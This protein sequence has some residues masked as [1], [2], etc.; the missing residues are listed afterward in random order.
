MARKC[1]KE[2]AIGQLNYILGS[3]HLLK[4]VDMSAVYLFGWMHKGGDVI[5]PGPKRKRENRASLRSRLLHRRV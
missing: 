3:G 1:L 2:W 5:E 4:S